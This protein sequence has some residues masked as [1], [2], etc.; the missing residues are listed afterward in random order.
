MIHD[1]P[2]IFILTIIFTLYC[3]TSFAQACDPKILETSIDYIDRGNRCEGFYGSK[4]SIGSSGAI[5]VVGLIKGEF[6]V[7]KHI[8]AILEV[9]LAI[10]IDQP[11]SI[12]SVGIAFKHKY[13]F[14]AIL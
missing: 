3:Q 1:Y 11:M 12:R 6:V 14:A 13:T 5:S 7:P 4:V 2:K 10:E 8:E 9:S